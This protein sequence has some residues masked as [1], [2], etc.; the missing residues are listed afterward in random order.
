M[1]QLLIALL[2]T[3]SLIACQKDETPVNQGNN[4]L[5][6]SW[7]NPQYTDTLVTYTRSTSLVENQVGFTFKSNNSLVCRENSGWCGTPPIVTADYE[8][9]WSWN[10]SL[11]N[12]KTSYW[13]GTTEFTWKIISMN[14]QELVVTVLKYGN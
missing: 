4:Y 7:I 12:I 5:V 10:D 14:Q 2:V 11:V 9:T 8:G 6:G 1:K 3:F 13:G